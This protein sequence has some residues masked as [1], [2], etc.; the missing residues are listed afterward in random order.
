M[1]RKAKGSQAERDLVNFFNE[2]GWCCI[3][4]A[5][6]GSSKYP[7]PDLICAKNSSNMAIE[8]KVS[9]NPY[10]YF[11]KKEIHE[12][13][14]FAKHMGA[15]SLVALKHKGKWSFLETLYLTDTGKNYRFCLEDHKN[16]LI[17]KNNLIDYSQEINTNETFKNIKSY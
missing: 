17:T 1:N 9:I 2:N 4:V 16:K 8:C 3:R 11:T 15:K 10:K 14:Y 5:G 6:S 13:D 12:L 7:C